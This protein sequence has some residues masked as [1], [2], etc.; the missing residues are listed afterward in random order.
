M[1]TPARIKGDEVGTVAQIISAIGGESF[2]ERLVGLLSELIDCERRLVVKYS[3]FAAPELLVNASLDS[4]AIENYLSGLYRLDPLLRLVESG[5]VPPVTSFDEIRTVDPANAFFDEIFKSGEI[6]DEL[7]ILLPS[8]GHAYIALCF[9]R[10]ARC[11]T[12][13]ELTWMRRLYPILVDAH[14]AHIRFAIQGRLGSVFGEGQ[15]GVAV[16]AQDGTLVYRNTPWVRLCEELP[17]QQLIDIALASPERVPVRLAERVLHWETSSIDT[18]QIRACRL[19][20]VETLSAGYLKGNAQAPLQGFY[21]RYELSPRE[22]QI[23]EKVMRGYCNSSIAKKLGLSPGTVKNYKQRLYCKLDITSE[24]EI[25]S[26]F[27]Q[28]LF[29]ESDPR[30]SAAD[31]TPGIFR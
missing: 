31:V 12:S 29:E 19:I 11:F 17:E 24:R 8:P 28:H 20:F 3:R 25:F 1:M 4:A 26:L 5:N 27:M 2:Y 21:Q 10:Q 22:S 15:V 13:T 18:A 9:D 7:A 23:V 14:A 16:V 6:L 30:A